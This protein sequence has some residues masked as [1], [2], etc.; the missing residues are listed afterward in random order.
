LN[1]DYCPQLAFSAKTQLLGGDGAQRIACDFP[2]RGYVPRIFFSIAGRTANRVVRVAE[3]RRQFTTS[4]CLGNG[5][6]RILTAGRETPI[7][8]RCWLAPSS[9]TLS[10]R[11]AHGL[12]C[13]GAC[14]TPRK[15][16]AQ[17]RF[18]VRS[19]RPIRPL[20]ICVIGSAHRCTTQSFASL[21]VSSK[22]TKPPSAVRTKT[23]TG[24]RKSTL[25]A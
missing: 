19:D 25:L 10:I 4:R 23:A 18:N 6:A 14:S 20:C 9:R 24:V 16:L 22:L 17:C 2:D 15:A 1:N 21:W 5:S 7:G 8:S 3:S 13:S 12:K 11:C